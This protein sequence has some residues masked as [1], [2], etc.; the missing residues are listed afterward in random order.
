MQGWAYG[1]FLVWAVALYWGEWIGTLPRVVALLVWGTLVIV[2]VW[3]MGRWL[4]SGPVS[5]RRSR[6][7][8]DR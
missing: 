5:A 1:M 6:W 2:H 4:T 8:A 7:Y 3:V